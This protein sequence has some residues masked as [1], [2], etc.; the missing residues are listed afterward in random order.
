MYTN[1]ISAI[2]WHLG[3]IVITLNP[4]CILSI[5][6]HITHF[7]IPDEYGTDHFLSIFL[8]HPDTYFILRSGSTPTVGSSR[9]S[10]SGFCS[11]AT[12]NDTLLIWPPLKN[13][14]RINIRETE[15]LCSLVFVKYTQ[16][17]HTCLLYLELSSKLL[18]YYHRIFNSCN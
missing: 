2:L 18:L 16:N 14:N 7:W 8:L 6:K 17:L 4:Q 10:S 15:S 9:I 12:D 3:L 1:T 13:E 11:N 5:G